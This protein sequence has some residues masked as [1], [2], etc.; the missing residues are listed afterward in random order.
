MQT[1]IKY[2]NVIFNFLSTPHKIINKDGLNYII[3]NKSEVIK[4]K[5]VKNILNIYYQ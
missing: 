4:N 2:K 1:G 5:L 3:L